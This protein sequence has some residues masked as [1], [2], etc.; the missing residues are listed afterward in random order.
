MGRIH[1]T[2]GGE[3]MTPVQVHLKEIADTKKI[4]NDYPISTVKRKQLTK[5][6]H[7]LYKQLSEYKK[8]GGK[9]E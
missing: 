4:I 2:K 1:R 6:L 9:M 8:L 3:T 5:H 7:R